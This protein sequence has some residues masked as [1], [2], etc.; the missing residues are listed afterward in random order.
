MNILIFCP[1]YRLEPE[2][3]ESLF[4]LDY[5]KNLVDILLTRSNPCDVPEYNRLYNYRRGRAALLADGYDAMMIIESDMI[6][7]RDAMLKLI[8]MDADIGIGL[9]AHRHQKDTYNLQAYH[10]EE[11]QDFIPLAELAR[12]WGERLPVTGGGLGCALVKRRVLAEHQFRLVMPN[13]VII[14]DCDSWLFHDAVRAGA[15]IMADTSIVCGHKTPAGVIL[16][17]TPHGVIET[18]G[19][20]AT[21]YHLR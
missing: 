13:A 7:P 16:W 15:R 9:Y 1:T 14:A 20:P 6:V 8:D 21:H 5:G 11:M 18:L 2:T 17:P 4:C 10:P 12:H 3:V 19:L